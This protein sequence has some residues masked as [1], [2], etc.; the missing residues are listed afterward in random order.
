[1]QPCRLDEFRRRITLE[2]RIVLNG[3]RG[4]NQQAL[5]ADA[6]YVPIPLKVKI[7]FPTGDFLFT[8]M[9]FPA[10]SLSLNHLNVIRQSHTVTSYFFGVP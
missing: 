5:T 2:R 9:A 6:V 10:I 3:E 4:E 8:L 7:H 1:M